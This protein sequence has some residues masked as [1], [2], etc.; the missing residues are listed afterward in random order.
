MIPCAATHS[1]VLET[2]QKAFFKGRL[3]ELTRRHAFADSTLG[4]A[5]L[6]VRAAKARM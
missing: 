2:R 4:M 5:F 1:R 6:P 3:V